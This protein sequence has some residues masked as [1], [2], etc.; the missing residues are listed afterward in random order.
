MDGE[1]G[2]ILSRGRTLNLPLA[3]L[4][5]SLKA[6]SA[7][8]RYASVQ[9]DGLTL[10]AVEREHI[11]RVLHESEWVIG[12]QTGAAARLGINRNTLNNRLRK[13]GINRPRQ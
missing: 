9:S 1:R 2:V 12:G 8:H 13:L 11:M 7:A 3:E 6:E 4:K 5:S 10:E